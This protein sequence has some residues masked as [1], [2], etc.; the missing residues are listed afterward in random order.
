MNRNWLVRDKNRLI[1]GPFT[2]ETITELYK[3]SKLSEDDEI[4]QSN[5][6]WFWVKEKSLIDHYL[7]QG[8]MQNQNDPFIES[9]KETDLELPNKQ[10]RKSDEIN[11]NLELPDLPSEIEL[12]DQNIDD[13]DI[14][15]EFSDDSTSQI[16]LDELEFSNV[17]KHTE[18]P[19]EKLDL[20]NNPISLPKENQNIKSKK[21]INKKKNNTVYN[22]NNNTKQRDDRYLYVII[23][24]LIFIIIGIF[25][26]YKNIINKP[27]NFDDVSFSTNPISSVLAQVKKKI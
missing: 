20:K 8:H 6:F 10:Q 25:Y 11:N 16:S 4:S 18:K 15:L 21:K 24:L 1:Q 26:Y 23:I 9:E 17:D 14:E 3:Q 12:N 19:L 22:D 13:E 7:I 5:G 2:K 27:I